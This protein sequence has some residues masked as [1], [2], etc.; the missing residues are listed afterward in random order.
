MAAPGSA[1]ALAWARAGH[2]AIQSDKPGGRVTVG[3]C[4][5]CII[6][7]LGLG[8]QTTALT[9]EGLT[10]CEVFAPLLEHSMHHPHVC[11]QGL[12][13]FGGVVT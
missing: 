4:L 10:I 12:V 11:Q 5:V 8:G 9:Q 1:P 3:G 2:T 7:Q 13:P 6:Q